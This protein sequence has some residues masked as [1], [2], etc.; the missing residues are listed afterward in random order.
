MTIWSMKASTA[1]ESIRHVGD[2][3]AL[4][5]AP[6]SGHRSPTRQRDAAGAA[7][8]RVVLTA[9]DAS[10]GT[11]TRPVWPAASANVT[12][13]SGTTDFPD[14]TRERYSPVA[15]PGMA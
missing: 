2:R 8:F 10:T 4:S 12:S 1:R 3:R 15:E 14:S 5:V 13:D 11:A 6:V 7:R 9:A